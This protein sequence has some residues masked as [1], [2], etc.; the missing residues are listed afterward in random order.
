[1]LDFEYFRRE[2]PE[3][4][5]KTAHA[6]MR[7]M[8]ARVLPAEACVHLGTSAKPLNEEPFDLD[9]FD[10]ILSRPNLDLKT[11]LLLVDT[12][13]RLLD[14]PD[15]EVALFA[16][17]SINTIEN[18]YTSRIEELKQQLQRQADPEILRTLARQYYELA[19]IHPGSIRNFY[20]RESFS[21]IKRLNRLKR[22]GKRDVILTVHILLALG[23]SGQA[24]KLIEQLPK[25]E[26][27]SYLRLEMEVAF[28]RKDTTTVQ[29]LCDRLREESGQLDED[30]RAFLSYWFEG[31]R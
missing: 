15:A 7:A 26:D 20:L 17:E 27:L 16:A 21:Y 2:P 30:S 31:T 5:P 3:Y 9:D 28:K 14:D 24:Q 11:N 10:R 8:E 18:R 22:M 19:Q 23:L 25:R 6:A 1:M 29:T 13:T 4:H 12:L